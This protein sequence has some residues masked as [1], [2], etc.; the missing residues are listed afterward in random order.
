MDGDE[1]SAVAID[2]RTPELLKLYRSYMDRLG[3]LVS[4][5]QGGTGI[6]T[7]GSGCVTYSD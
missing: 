4:H 6:G 2:E 5:E 3:P 7:G 1:N